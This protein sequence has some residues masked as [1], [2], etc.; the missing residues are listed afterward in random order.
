MFRRIASY[1]A[2]LYIVTLL[3]SVARLAVKSLIAKS[4][5]KEAFGIYAYFTTVVLLGSSL[6]AFGLVRTMAKHVAANRE[7]EVFAPTV[8]AVMVLLIAASVVLAGLGLLLSSWLDWVYVFALLSVGPVTLFE[9]ARSTLRGQFDQRRE[10]FAA[11][12]AIVMQMGLVTLLVLLVDNRKAPVWGLTIAHAI[13]AAFITLYFLRRYTTHWLPNQLSRVYRSSDFRHLL[14]LTTPLWVADI[15]AIVGHQADLFIV[16][17]QLGY[18][19]LAEYAAAITFTGLLNQLMTVIARVFLITFASGFYQSIDKYKRV[20]SLN[21]AFVS[22]LGLLITIVAM[23][24]TPLIFTAEY[25]RTPMLVL[26]LS[27]A[28]VFKSVEVLNTALTIAQ[29]YPQA[30]RNSKIWITLLYLPLA[31]LLV[32]QWG[33][34]GAAWSNVFSWAGYALIHALY[35]RKLLPMHAAHT[36]RETLVGTVLYVGLAATV[37]LTDAGWFGLLA[38]PAYLGLGHV[39]RLWDLAQMPDLVRRLLPH[40]LT[41]NAAVS[42]LLSRLPE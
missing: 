7:E 8:S 9:V 5:G 23:P 33:V 30:N 21:L 1:S 22:T 34:V 28:F 26:I 29:D 15:L 14:H 32:K 20:S 42:S 31:F 19:A 38:V 36:F 6:L 13:L 3:S 12:L 24:L 40:R 2:W 27:T 11:F 4:V 16:Q 37:W 39:L 41:E 17:G 35:M 25:T 10:I 18:R